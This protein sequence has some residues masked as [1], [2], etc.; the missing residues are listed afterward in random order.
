MELS[1]GF[2]LMELILIMAILAIAA[3]VT[4]PALANFFRGRSLDSE[5]R[6]LLAL[7]RQGQTRAVAEGLPTELWIDA[8]TGAYGLEVE[9]SYEPNDPKAVQVT[10]DSALQIETG[11]S[12][13]PNAAL[14][15]L[16][17]SEQPG[18]KPAIASRHPNLPRIRFLPD[19][20]LDE[21]SPQSVR[22]IGHDGNS[23]WLTLARSRLNY[24]ISN[25][26]GQ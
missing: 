8:K 14:A 25:R 23:V 7:T 22:L 17:N 5:A 11:N 20:S 2:T 26:K 12:L 21:S 10:L 19:G 1:R 9:P 3:S 6:R 13:T 15:G 4:A 16:N 18:N 24:E